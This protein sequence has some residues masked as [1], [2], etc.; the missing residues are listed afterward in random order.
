MH[1]RSDANELYFH[2]YKILETIYTATFHRQL[3]QPLSQL[4]LGNYLQ[5]SYIIFSEDDFTLFICSRSW[6]YDVPHTHRECILKN[7]EFIFDIWLISPYRF[8]LAYNTSKMLLI[9]PTPIPFF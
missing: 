4:I 3:G 1:N 7:L 2:R 6:E 9:Q 8:D 5:N